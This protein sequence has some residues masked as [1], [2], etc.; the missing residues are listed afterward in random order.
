M[1]AHANES[2]VKA[3]A[4]GAGLFYNASYNNMLTC[5]NITDEF[6]EC[7][8]QTGFN[9][10]SLYFFLILYFENNKT[11]TNKSANKNNKQ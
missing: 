1:L 11:Q 2:N 3:L 10:I 6:I 7:A 5:F 9:Q 4:V 8:D